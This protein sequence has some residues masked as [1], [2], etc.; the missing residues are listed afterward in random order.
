MSRSSCA[1]IRAVAAMLLVPAVSMALVALMEK[2]ANAAW[3]PLAEV[4]RRA[5]ER[6]LAVTEAQGNVG[7]AKS[8]ITGARVSSLGNP[9]LQVILDHG[10]DVTRD[11]QVLG[12]LQLPIEV[13]GQRGKRI[14]EAETFVDWRTMNREEVRARVAGAAIAAYGDALVARA[15]QVLAER[16]EREAQ[17][18]AQYF[19]ARLAAGDVNLVDRSLADAELARWS[20]LSAEAGIILLRARQELELLMGM[21]HL[22]DPPATAAPEAPELHVNTADVFVGR[23]LN[24]SPLLRSLSKE[25][26]YWQAQRDRAESEKNPPIAVILSGGRGDTGEVRYGGGLGWT[27]PITRRNQGEIARAYAEQGRTEGVR[28]ATQRALG[29][30]ADHA[31]EAYSKVRSGI[32]ALD[33][34]GIPA[35]QRVVD[36][37]QAAFLAGKV[38]LVRT[39][40]ARRDLAAA[41][42]RRL[43]FLSTAWHTYGDMVALMGDLP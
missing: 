12:Q 34:V 23:V 35:A 16:G 41:Q 28:E 18:E 9:S 22:D 29:I 20:Q 19:A 36:A 37:T 2:P 11:A 38:E 27:F 31:F 8:S 33:K 24:V 39:F 17:A 3:P 42:G 25:S 4:Y 40:I 1:F 6:A 21:G 5:R 15:R 26:Q 30:E 14:R 43:D 32:E 7:V 10:R 13:A